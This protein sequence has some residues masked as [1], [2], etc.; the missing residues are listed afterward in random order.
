MGEGLLLA[1]AGGGAVE[2]EREGVEELELL[3]VLE[4]VIF[5]EPGGRLG[6]TCELRFERLLARQLGVEHPV[7]DGAVV[8]GQHVEQDHVRHAVAPV[9]EAPT[10]HTRDQPTIGVTVA[11]PVR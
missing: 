5:F 2:I 9:V 4:H 11:V 1:R 7:G 10:V 8:V 3:V 6:A